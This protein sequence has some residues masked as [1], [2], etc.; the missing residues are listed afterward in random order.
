MAAPDGVSSLGHRDL[1]NPLLGCL[2]GLMTSNG[3]GVDMAV[4][5]GGRLWTL[6][7]RNGGLWRAGRAGRVIAAGKQVGE[8]AGAVWPMV[9]GRQAEVVCAE[10]LF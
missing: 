2:L 7:T 5:L 6:L 9:V 3:F 10:W 4:L 8:Q 1:A